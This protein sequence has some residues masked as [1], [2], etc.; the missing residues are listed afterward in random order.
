MQ[1]GFPKFNLFS[2]SQYYVIFND[3][4]V[5]YIPNDSFTVQACFYVDGNELDLGKCFRVLGRFRLTWML[6]S[7]QKISDSSE[8]HRIAWM[9]QNYLNASD[10]HECF[11]MVWRLSILLNV[12]ELLE[13]LRFS[14]MFQNG[15]KVKDTS[16]CF[17]ITWMFKIFMN[18]S[19]WS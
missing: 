9:L 17:R 12:S 11:R 16:E 19:E 15:L 2:P 4:K 10:F 6:L 5:N 7:R 13:C 14:W 8:C 1:Q 18:I 3:Y